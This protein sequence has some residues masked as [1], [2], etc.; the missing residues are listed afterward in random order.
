MSNLTEEELKA[1]VPTFLQ[2]MLVTHFT[3]DVPRDHALTLEALAS[4]IQCLVPAV[5]TWRQCHLYFGRSPFVR[6]GPDVDI[7]VTF[8]DC[9]GMAIDDSIYIDCFQIQPHPIQAR[10]AA[11]CGSTPQ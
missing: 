3:C 4:A 11:A 2:T 7:T 5:G 6:P 9:A 10:V 1:A 8:H